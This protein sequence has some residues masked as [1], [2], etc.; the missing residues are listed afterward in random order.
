MKW[1]WKAV[2][3]LVLIPLKTCLYGLLKAPNTAISFLIS[4][5][6]GLNT[7]DLQSV[8]YYCHSES[9]GITL[10]LYTL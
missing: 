1:K 8:F 4:K 2:H 10:T 6:R 7:A 3:R 5:M 9:Q